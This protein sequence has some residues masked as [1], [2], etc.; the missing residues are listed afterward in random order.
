MYGPFK[1]YNVDD[2]IGEMYSRLLVMLE[3][4]EKSLKIVDEKVASSKN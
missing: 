4:K 2:F 3:K 1:T